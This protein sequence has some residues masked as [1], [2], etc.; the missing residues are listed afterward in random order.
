MSNP[1]PTT[2]KG[3]G[4]ERLVRRVLPSLLLVAFV[5]AAYS[6]SFPGVFLFDD[7]YHIVEN[8][9]IRQLWPPWDL[10]SVERPVVEF[11]LA[12]NYAFGG[13]N[14]WGYHAFNLVVHILAALTLFGLVRRTITSCQ[15]RGRKPTDTP[16]VTWLAPGALIGRVD[17]YDVNGAAVFAFAVALLWAVHPLQ[18][19]SVTYV[20]QRGE[21]LMGLF[22]LLTLYCA[23]RGLH[24]SRRLGWY[25]AAIIACAL[26][27]ASKAVMV[28]VPVMMFV[29]DHVF[30]RKGASGR[31]WV[32][33]AGLAATW[34]VLWICGVTGDI[35]DPEAHRSHVGFGYHG[36]TPLKYAAT[37][38]G[39]ILNYLQ[40]CFWPDGLCLD[41][42]WPVASTAIVIVPP[43]LVVLLLLGA[44]AWGLVRRSWLGF[45]GA[46]FFVILAPTSSFI[47]IKDLAFEH[48]MYLP[49]AA[50]LA[51]VLFG[52]KTRLDALF[53]RLSTGRNV[54]KWTGGVATV[55]VAMLLTHGT[56]QRNKD[57][58]SDLAIWADVA[59]KR[60]HNARARVAVGN[61]LLARNRVDEAIA[62]YREAVAIRADF[63]DGQCALGMGLARKGALDE[64]VT[65]YRESLR[66]DPNLAK[67]HY[68]LGNALNRLGKIEESIRSFRES[69]RIQPRFADAHCNLG[70]ALAAQWQLD[71]AMTEYREAIRIRP[72]LANAH[73]GLG[74][75]LV[76]L[77]R[78]GEAVAAFKEAIHIQPDYANAHA[79]LAAA[80]FDRGE[81]EKA[82]RYAREA[83]RID[84]AHAAAA[85]TLN[86]A[87]AAISLHGRH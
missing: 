28:T 52:G 17:P 69:L 21:S 82:A 14:L 71:E 87:Q 46:W 70:N 78:V 16:I 68:N 19:Q 20:I 4:G 8:E 83:L 2:V 13:L 26:G 34:G 49:L 67:A 61:A 51:V 11:S 66:L 15:S 65:A 48:R 39:V 80:Y 58:R 35:L 75:V 44:T 86:A 56:Y 42:D 31:R 6:N 12:V 47:P 18:T 62:A 72:G 33:Y 55:V 24:S 40:L 22:Y 73:K 50:V 3:N 53:G 36:I 10:L 77:G 25:T 79:N 32:L 1:P 9:R 54:M 60:P 57:Y 43:A 29:Y 59:A 85:E 5:V 30:L 38:P 37:Q 45:V 41:Y 84:P 74:D 7:I 23:I 27:M 81:Y 64:A 76:R 63:A